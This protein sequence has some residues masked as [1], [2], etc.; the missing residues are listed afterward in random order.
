L[1]VRPAT[2]FSVFSVSQFDFDVRTRIIFILELI[3]EK[4][5][6]ISGAVG[7]SGDVSIL[8]DLVDRLRGKKR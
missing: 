4:R 8:A 7:S 6:I 1:W 2:N 5:A 3:E